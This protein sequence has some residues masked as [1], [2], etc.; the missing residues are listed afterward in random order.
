MNYVVKYIRPMAKPKNLGEFEILVLAALLRLGD[1]AYGAKVR[2]EIENRANRTVSVGALYATL[3]RME[4]K[5][6]V[7][8]Y[9]GGATAAR[10]GRAKRYYN[11][12]PLGQQKLDAAVSG[13]NAMLKGVTAWTKIPTR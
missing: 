5:G 3:G 13:L 10:G 11:L 6:L 7:Q 2:T 4:V 9:T 8:S 1:D 12:T